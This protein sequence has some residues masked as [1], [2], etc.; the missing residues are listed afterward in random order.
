MLAKLPKP[1]TWMIRPAMGWAN[2]EL[3]ST[4]HSLGHFIN[5]GG[6]DHSH[7]LKCSW[8][9]VTAVRY[10]RKQ[11]KPDWLC[12]LLRHSATKWGGLILRLW[13]PQHVQTDDI[14]QWHK[15]HAIRCGQMKNGH[16]TDSLCLGY[17]G[18]CAWPCDSSASCWAT[19]LMGCSRHLD[20]FHPEFHFSPHK[21]SVNMP[22]MYS[23]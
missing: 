7:S 1:P 13:S 14:K 17:P 16:N 12:H 8:Q 21:P 9:Y 11:L 23:N 18:P 5:I 4:R 10:K 20:K 6:N 19:P 15:I 3:C 2:V 22:H